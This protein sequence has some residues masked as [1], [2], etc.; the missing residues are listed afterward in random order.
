MLYQ[1]AWLSGLIHSE[2][3]IELS[4]N[5]YMYTYIHTADYIVLCKHINRA[6][7]TI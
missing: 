5:V 4:E 6:I 2:G 1:C 7:S 3:F